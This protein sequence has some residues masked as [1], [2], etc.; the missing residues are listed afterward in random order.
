MRSTEVPPSS[1]KFSSAPTSSSPR[2]SPT[3]SATSRSPGHEG[4]ACPYRGR[5]PAAF[6]SAA[7]STL[8]WE[9]SGSRS[10]VTKIDGIMYAG[11]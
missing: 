8:P 1:K 7:R 6:G 10:S 5:L 2:S 9:V 3:I 11:S 4:T